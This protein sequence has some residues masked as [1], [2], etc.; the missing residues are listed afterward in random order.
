VGGR[1][2]FRFGIVGAIRVAYWLRNVVRDEREPAGVSESE[3]L[4]STPSDS[5]CE[6]WMRRSI[7]RYRS[8]FHFD[9]TVYPRF[10]KYVICGKQNLMTRPFLNSL[11][12]APN[13]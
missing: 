9:D 10:A 6:I 12:C 5:V 2:F 4:S 7:G 13:E 3:L 11:Y 1:Y 8:K